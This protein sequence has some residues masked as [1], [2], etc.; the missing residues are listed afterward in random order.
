LAEADGRYADGDYTGAEELYS[1]VLEK[2]AEGS[3]P[4]GRHHP[5][6]V[7]FKLGRALEAQGKLQEAT[8]IYVAA[9]NARPPRAIYNELGHITFTKLG[10]LLKNANRLKESL[11][12]HERAAKLVTR[13]EPHVNRG[14]TLQELGRFPE[15][16]EAFAE[17]LRLDGS[18]DLA[19]FGLCTAELPV[20][21]PSP[22]AI[23]SSRARYGQQLHALSR[24]YASAAPEERAR[25]GEAVGQLQPFYL[26]YQG[27]DDRDLQQVYGDMIC[28]LMAARLPRWSRPPARRRPSRGNRIRVGFVSRHFFSAHSVWKLPLRGWIEAIDRDRFEVFGYCTA[29]EPDEKRRAAAPPLARFVHGPLSTEAWC[30]AI[31]Q[32]RPDALIYPEFGMD[33]ESLPLGAL[34]L[35]PV[36]M[37][38]LGHPITSGMP[39]ISHFLSSDLME[40]PDSD[41][42]YT[43]RLVRLPN[44]GFAYTPLRC[45]PDALDRSGLG[46]GAADVLFWCCQSLYKLLP[47]NDDVFPRIARGL[48]GCK[49][50]F[51]R[52][53]REQSNITE[54]FKTRLAKSFHL[55]GLR[56]EDHCVFLP[57]M[58]TEA[59]AGM[60]AAAD[61]FLDGID[62]SGCNTTLEAIA[63]NLPVVTWPGKLMRARHAQ[64]ALRLMGVEETIANSKE[65]YIAIAVRLGR[66]PDRRRRI[67]RLYA[68]NKHRLYDDPA[69]IRAL[70]DLLEE[71]VGR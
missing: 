8:E 50:A 69:P 11:D 18:C 3:F 20:I 17:A 5:A 47:Q 51:I 60:C 9:V 48:A 40:P 52:D 38:S 56:M 22:E 12:C 2:Y 19:R 28:G 63:Q 32:D 58:S 23:A 66:E 43:E 64:A 1:R 55:H 44:L 41:A 34:W 57:H 16:S 29:G 62:W 30:E 35:A 6:F 59:F 21:Y 46:I 54:V 26:P 24:H 10:N 61:V 39:T 65:D 49:F 15:A 67:A 45:D 71:L 53:H 25:A 68:R 36:Q 31:T 37:T 27:H 4:H 7:L 42:H 33:P 13:P 70:E 14:I